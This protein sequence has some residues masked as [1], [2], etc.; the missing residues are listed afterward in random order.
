MF[1][2]FGGGPVRAGP[3][4]PGSGFGKVPPTTAPCAKSRQLMAPRPVEPV[5]SKGRPESQKA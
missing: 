4:S 5:K 2:L 3:I 1:Y